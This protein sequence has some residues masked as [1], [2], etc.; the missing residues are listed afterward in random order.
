[1]TSEYPDRIWFY[2]PKFWAA[3]RFMSRQQVEALKEEVWR[4]AEQ[5]DLE[6]LRRF[7]FI[8]IGNPYKREKKA[9]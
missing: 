1:M 4:M 9:S 7:D 5:K 6:G 3:T 8:Y 2:P